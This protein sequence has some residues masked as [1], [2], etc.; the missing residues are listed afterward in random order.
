[1][2]LNSIFK[3]TEI[4]NL[5]KKGKREKKNYHRVVY[6]NNRK[7]SYTEDDITDNINKKLPKYAG[8]RIKTSKV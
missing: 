3:T 5:F 8:N 4:I 7:P 6:I 2:K 1:M